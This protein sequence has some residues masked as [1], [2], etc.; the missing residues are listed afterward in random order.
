MSLSSEWD[1]E[2]AK[3]YCGATFIEHMPEL[4]AVLES[5]ERFRTIPDA[6][7]VLVAV[8]DI[9]RLCRICTNSSTKKWKV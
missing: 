2:V 8:Q 9:R 1:Q 3:C 5:V 6:E 4:D 7:L